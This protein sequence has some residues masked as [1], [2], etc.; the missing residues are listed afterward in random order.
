MAACHLQKLSYTIILY[1]YIY[2]KRVILAYQYHYRKMLVIFMFPFI[3]LDHRQNEQ[4]WSF[5]VAVRNNESD[6][7]SQ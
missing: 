2:F 7:F 3:N 5:A 6:I 1:K 4:Q